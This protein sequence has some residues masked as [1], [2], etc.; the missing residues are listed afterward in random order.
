MLEGQSWKDWLLAQVW[1]C[2]LWIPR[3]PH[4]VLMLC[5]LLQHCCCYL[6][7]LAQ[8]MPSSWG[9]V[10]ACMYSYSLFLIFCYC[11]SAFVKSIGSLFFFLAPALLQL[12][13]YFTSLLLLL[14]FGPL[15]SSS[16]LFWWYN[17]Y[18]CCY[19]SS[20]SNCV[21]L[22]CAIRRLL[23]SSVSFFI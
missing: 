8:L 14:L 3:P 16:S 2:D 20:F 10:E 7:G 23:I 15:F 9:R 17:R 5:L 13:G 1:L 18:F 6:I 11:I 19:L 21:P 4:L 12:A 22:C